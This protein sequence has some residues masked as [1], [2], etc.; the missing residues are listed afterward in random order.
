MS[1][2]VRVGF[3]LVLVAACQVNPD[4]D[5]GATRAAIING[6]T[7]T[8]DPNVPLVY[9]IDGEYVVGMCTGTLISPRVVLTAAH[10]VA[11][12]SEATEW[13]VYFGSTIE[14]EPD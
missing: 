5:V 11:P 14:A 13:A 3:L 7:T 1:S 9:L 10:C 8:G 6:S 2:S 4:R 12:D